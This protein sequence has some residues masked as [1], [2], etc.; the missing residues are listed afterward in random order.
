MPHRFAAFYESFRAAGAI[1][2]WEGGLSWDA[3]PG[4]LPQRVTP[5]NDTAEIASAIARRLNLPERPTG[6]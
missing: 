3:A 4:A 6:R 5:L 2:W 1:R